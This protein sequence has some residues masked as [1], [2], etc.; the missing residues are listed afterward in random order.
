MNAAESARSGGIQLSRKNIL[1]V[2]SNCIIPRTFAEVIFHSGHSQIAA[3][4]PSTPRRSGI[5]GRIIHS[6]FSQVETRGV[7]DIRIQF[8]EHN[9]IL[10][11][12]KASTRN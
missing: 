1:C 6:T 11:V 10:K 2:S 9:L 12:A 7:L 4:L 5:I 8:S 3:L